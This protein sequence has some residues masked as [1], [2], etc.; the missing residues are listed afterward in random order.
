MNLALLRLLCIVASVLLGLGLAGPCMTIRPHFG[1]FTGVV[2]VLQPSFTASVSYSVLGGIYALALDGK[3]LIA[4][5]VLIFS[6]VFPILKL[7]VLWVAV[8][9]LYPELTLI[10][11]LLE[12]LGKYSM[13]DVFVMALLV[14]SIKGLPGGSSVELHW[15]LF[16]FGFSTLL[17][18][19]LAQQVRKVSSGPTA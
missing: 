4:S 16:M 14:L 1:N 19:W 17:T 3:F 2:N 6:V 13:I 8:W 12:K 18:M 10:H 15:G 5:V 11:H 7:S 9:N